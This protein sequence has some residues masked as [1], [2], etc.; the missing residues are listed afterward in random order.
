MLGDHPEAYGEC[1]ILMD[2]HLLEISRFFGDRRDAEMR[3]IYSALRRRPDGRSLGFVHD[4]MWQEAALVLGTAFEPGR[5]RGDH[6]AVGALVPDI[7][8]RP[9]FQKLRRRVENNS[10]T[11]FRLRLPCGGGVIKSGCG[12]SSWNWGQECPQNSQAGKHAL[13]SADILVCGFGW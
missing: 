5:V 11:E 12:L 2:L 4:Y 6:G 3:E 8:A 1:F 7:R 13:R 9:H 10:G